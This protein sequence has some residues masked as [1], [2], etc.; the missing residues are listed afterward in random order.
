M[1]VNAK[2]L[3]R[4]VTRAL[5]VGLVPMIKGSPA[6]GKSDIVRQV[7]KEHNLKVI[8]FRLSQADPTDLNG[9]PNLNADRTKAGYVPME[10]FPIE[11]DDIPEGYAGWLLFLDEINSAPLMVQAAAYK[12]ILDRMVGQRHIH[13]NVAIIGAGNLETDKAITHKLNPAIQ[14]RLAH[15]TL[16]VVAKLWDEWAVK[17]NIDYRIRSFIKFKPENLYQFKPDHNNDTFPSPRTWEFCSKLVTDYK[18][19]PAEDIPLLA[20]VVDEAAAREFYAYA[21]IFKDLITIP[22]IL[23]DPTGLRIPEEPSILYALSGSLG[24]HMT[25]NDASK[26]MQFIQRMPIEFQIMGLQGAI[27]RIP[28]LMQHTAM[29]SWISLNSKELF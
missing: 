16:V 3:P 26:L 20:S 19:I 10:T 5:R 17:H 18:T 27:Q 1:E 4:L 25:E 12:L 14:T 7:A 6:I 13:K 24:Q 15:F 22:Q 21:Q 11:G 29:K 8:D 9:F 2:Q 28:A 23:K